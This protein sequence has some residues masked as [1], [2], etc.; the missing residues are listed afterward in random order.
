MSDENKI[1]SGYWSIAT[2]KHLKEFRTDS[3]NLDE[4]DGLNVAGKAGRLLGV[5]RGNSQIG[6][7]KKIEKMANQVGISRQELHKIV[8]PHLADASDKK[9]KILRSSAGD[10]VG[11]EEYVFTNSSVLEITGEVFERSNPSSVERLTIETMDETKK[12]PYL[13]RDLTELLTGRGFLEQDINLAFTLQ[14]QF[15]LIQMLSKT[16]STDKIISNE[17]VW[18]PNHEKIAMAVSNLDMDNKQSLKEVI[19]IIQYAQGH[20]LE[21]L[22]PLDEKLIMLAKK[23]GMINPIVILSSRGL[24]KEFGFSSNLLGSGGYDDDILDDVKLLLASIRFGEHYT[25]YSTIESPEKFLRF[26]LDRGK[27]GPHAANETDYTLLEKKGII[28]VTYGTKYSYWRQRNESGYFLELIRRDVAEAALEIVKSADYHLAG[29]TDIRQYGELAD[30]GSYI[31]PEESRIKLGEVPD[32][33]KEAE[34]YL[35]QVL[36]DELL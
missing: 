24:Q 30:T 28:K 25:P 34:E 19:E 26:L 31:S 17:Y 9:V 12:I 13:H 10:I 20:P 4:F 22:P 14:N 35:N 33:V 11:V 8:L 18:G 15:R 36:R 23:T 27:I 2:Q 21:K 16:N 5:L 29:E 7:I 6:N 1:K 32:Q 3:S